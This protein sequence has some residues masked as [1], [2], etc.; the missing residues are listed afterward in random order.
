[1]ILQVSS[2]GW[3][4]SYGLGQ[5]LPALAPVSIQW[6][7]QSVWLHPHREAWAL[8]LVAGRIRK[9]EPG[10]SLGAQW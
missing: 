7:S 3:A 9:Q 10:V 6:L 2:L 8:Y 4:H 1:M 5:G